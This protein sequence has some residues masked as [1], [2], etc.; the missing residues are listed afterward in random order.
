MNDSTRS[1][2][3]SSSARAT[4]ASRSTARCTTDARNARRSAS[5]TAWIVAGSENGDANS[6]TAPIRAPGRQ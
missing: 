3:S 5:V 4:T 2:S 6:D 1:L